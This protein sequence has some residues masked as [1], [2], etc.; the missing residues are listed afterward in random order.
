MSNYY[1]AAYSYVTYTLEKHSNLHTPDFHSNHAY[2]LERKQ[3]LA[4][5]QNHTLCRTCF[6]QYHGR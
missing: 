1:T 4:V 6:S 2:F 3:N 5:T